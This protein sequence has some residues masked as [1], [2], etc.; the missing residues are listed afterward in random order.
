MDLGQTRVSHGKVWVR[1]RLCRLI[2]MKLRLV[3]V[4]WWGV[5]KMLGW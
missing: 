2:W 3:V 5:L 1:G 4:W